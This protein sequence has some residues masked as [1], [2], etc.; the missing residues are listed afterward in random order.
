M[1]LSQEQI[2]V[3][4][5]YVMVEPPLYEAVVTVLENQ[6]SANWVGWKVRIDRVNGMLAP[7]V[8]D[9]LDVGWHPDY[10][11]Y[12]LNAFYSLNEQRYMPVRYC[13]DIT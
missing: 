9:Y 10:S 11:H 8:G 6:C 4:H 1:K 7:K 13:F 12:A 3:G 2:Q 5:S